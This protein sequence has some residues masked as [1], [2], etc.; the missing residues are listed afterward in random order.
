MKL[1]TK[2][3]KKM[4]FLSSRRGVTLLLAILTIGLVSLIVLA[5]AQYFLQEFLMSKN[6]GDSVRA[7][8]IAESGIEKGLY[9][10]SQLEEN[11][12]YIS[13]DDFG[14]WKDNSGL[15]FSLEIQKIDN[16]YKIESLG[17]VGGILRKLE[18][19]KRKPTI[20]K[21]VNS[22]SNSTLILTTNNRLF[23]VGSNDYG[24][25]ADCSNTLVVQKF[26]EFP[27][28]LGVPVYFATGSHHTV[29]LTNDGKAY[30]V[31]DGLAFG[32]I[33]QICLWQQIGIGIQQMYIGDQST[34]LKV[35]N[36]FQIT[37]R[38]GSFQNSY[39]SSLK[40]YNENSRSY[41]ESIDDI[42]C[43]GLTTLYAID[44]KGGVYVI[45]GADP[46]WPNTGY[47]V[48]SNGSFYAILKYVFS[49]NSTL[50]SHYKIFTNPAI[51]TEAFVKTPSG[52][53]YARGENT[54]YNNLGLGG[55]G[56][57]NFQE[58]TNLP[59]PGSNIVKIAF[60]YRH[61]LM[62]DNSGN[63]YVIGSNGEGQ[64]GL[65]SNVASKTSWYQ[66]PSS[67]FG[68]QKIQDI[69]AGDYYSVV[70]TENG[71]VYATGTNDA[72][73]LGL[74]YSSNWPPIKTWTKVEFF[75]P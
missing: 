45:S 4:S 69:G 5:I 46:Y 16:G 15:E 28:N 59:V 18:V 49:E 25:L 65:G 8:Y 74:G 48:S 60:G 55:S 72:A 61:T 34:I 31:G 73:Q 17:N 63:L 52:K 11:P 19:T 9:I 71:E 7:Y 50:T 42:G 57:Y 37:G 23:M 58:V 43:A 13:F 10:L 12:N 27:Q 32:K 51:N 21:S 33:T 75:G 66:V 39:W 70:V 36:N 41:S 68:G 20:A 67:Y 40:F 54:S 6:I 56:F 2:K 53:I 24:K 29:V 44:N 3:K 14:K 1:F 62:L 26:K 38:I 22:S 30:A 47:F 35:G 64:L